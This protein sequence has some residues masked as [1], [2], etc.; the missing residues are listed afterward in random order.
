MAPR[1][2]GRPARRHHSRPASLT[3]IVMGP[4]RR[5]NPSRTGNLELRKVGLLSIPQFPSL[6]H[7]VELSVN[8]GHVG[9][10]FPLK[11][12]M[13]SRLR[14]SESQALTRTKKRQKTGPWL[15]G[16]RPSLFES[17]PTILSPCSPLRNQPSHRRLSRLS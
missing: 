15:R 17:S 14:R 6:K 1:A 5:P 9:F 8:L 11:L 13:L 7:L 2:S 16:L 4:V 10:Q 3:R 12:F